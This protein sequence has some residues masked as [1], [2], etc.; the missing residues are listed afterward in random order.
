MSFIP[1]VI[2]LPENRRGRDFVI[3][4]L[5]G[6]TPDLFR[7]LRSVG[8]DPL[9]DR[10]FAVGDLIDR[11]PDSLGALELLKKPWFFSAKGNHEDI[12]LDHMRKTAR[13]GAGEFLLNGGGW[14]KNKD[15][16]DRAQACVD[17]VAALPHVLVVGRGTADRFHV[18]HGELTRISKKG[19]VKCRKDT[20]VDCW[21]QGRPGAHPI[22]EVDLLWDRT[23]FAGFPSKTPEVSPALSPTFCGHTM[24]ID[25]RLKGSHVNIDTGAFKRY[26]HNQGFRTLTLIN[27]QEYVRNL[28]E[29]SKTSDLCLVAER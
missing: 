4:D 1:K 5:H 29:K 9:V 20:D 24:G 14:W 18:V 2:A 10:V 6:C 19:F 3:G 16:Y 11:G 17:L 15:E 8:F 28:R 25:V 23:L 12:F 22:N 21:L 26:T 7:T 27:A 13:Y